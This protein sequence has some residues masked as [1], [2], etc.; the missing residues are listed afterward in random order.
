M[1]DPSKPY[2]PIFNM[3]CIEDILI[4]I[5][6]KLLNMPDSIIKNTYL[7]YFPNNPFVLYT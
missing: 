1:Q 7:N 5:N 4:K 2:K 3:K 6:Q